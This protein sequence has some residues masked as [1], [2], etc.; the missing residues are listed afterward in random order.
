MRSTIRRWPTT[1]STTTGSCSTSLTSFSG[2]VPQPLLSLC[3]LHYQGC[4]CSPHP[5]HPLRAPDGTSLTDVANKVAHA[6]DRL[7]MFANAQAEEIYNHGYPLI[8]GVGTASTPVG[9][10][11]FSPLVEPVLCLVLCCVV[12]SRHIRL[13]LRRPG[14]VLSPNARCSD[15]GPALLQGCVHLQCR[16][17]RAQQFSRFWRHFRGFVSAQLRRGESLSPHSVPRPATQH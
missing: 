12:W 10:L 3:T 9:R 1:Q 11:L 2:L 15:C 17:G 16:A 14:R 7:I 13:S 4:R 6:N 8:F 5:P